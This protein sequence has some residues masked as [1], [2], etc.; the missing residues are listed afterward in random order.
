MGLLI[1]LLNKFLWFGLFMS[2]LNL[3]RHLYNLIQTYVASSEVE[4]AKYL[5]TP[6]GLLFLALS[7]SYVLMTIFSGVVLK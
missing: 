5:M 4:T 2:I 7:V 3:I 1:A 6:M